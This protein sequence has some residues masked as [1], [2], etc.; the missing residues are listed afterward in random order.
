[1]ETSPIGVALMALDGT[2][3]F[4]N[5]AFSRLLGRPRSDLVGCNF[6]DITHPD[7]RE[8][9]AAVVTELAGGLRDHY[10]V[11]KRYVR[12][13]G[14]AVDTLLSV[15]VLTDQ[16]G[17]P[18]QFLSQVVDLTERRLAEAEAHRSAERQTVVAALGE[19]ALQGLGIPDLLQ[20]AVSEVAR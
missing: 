13:D 15:S 4:A 10:Q 9:D 12:P 3:L 16:S 19:H 20:E 2:M 7:D 6:L 1:M 11:E 8:R 17:R 18:T 14:S 5:P